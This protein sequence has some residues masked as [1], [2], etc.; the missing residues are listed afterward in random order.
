MIERRQQCRE[1]GDDS[2]EKTLPVSERASERD[3]GRVDGA[4]AARDNSRPGQQRLS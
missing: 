3:T 1:R 4:M 2:G